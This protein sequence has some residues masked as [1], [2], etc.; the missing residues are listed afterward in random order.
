MEA[1]YFHVFPPEVTPWD[2]MLLWGTKYSR[3]TLHIDPYNWTG[4][5]AVLH[6]RKR[7]KV[8]IVSISMFVFGHV[9]LQRM[10]AMWCYMGV[11]H[12]R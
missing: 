7:W 10:D 9:V 2:A 1:N 4:T 6:G 5:N 3:S 8:N 12:G 11:K